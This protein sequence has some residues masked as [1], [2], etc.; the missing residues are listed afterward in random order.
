MSTR[1]PALRVPPIGFAHRGA[2][3]HA[4]ENTLESFLLAR[5][6]GATGLESDAWLTRDGHVV[7]DHDGVVGRMRKRPL[8]HFERSRVP[9][10]IPTLDELYL[11][12]GTDYDLALDIKDPAAIE[13]VVAIA[14][15]YRATDRLWVCHHD[16]RLVASWRELDPDIKLV[17]STRLRL[18]KDGAERRAAQLAEAGIDAVNLH[19]SDWNGGLTTLFHRFE[20][21]TL[22]WD[23][24]FERQL[25]E[26]VDMGIDGVF[27]DHTDRMV[28]VIAKFFPED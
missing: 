17:D 1:L 5:R 27:S 23:A 16:W 28:G 2:K 21:Y 12:C 6:L 4:R 20:R 14:Q 10:H 11:A 22:A 8:F 3:A 15:R 25:D 18:M 24:Q 9:G 19:V 7:L 26:V 13:A